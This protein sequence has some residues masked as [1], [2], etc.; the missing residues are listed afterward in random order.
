MRILATILLGCLFS[1]ACLD[2][3]GVST[4]S[5]TDAENNVVS[6]E[7]S[8]STSDSIIANQGNDA[9]RVLGS[10][11]PTLD[12]HMTSD[13]TSAFYVVEIFSGLV[14]IDTNL[15]L[16][17]E[18]AESWKVS[19][20]GKTYTFKL[21]RGVKFHNGKTVRAQD[22]KWSLERAAAP[23][24]ASPVADTYLNDIVGATD[25]MKGNANEIS[26]VTVVDDRTLQ[27]TIDAPKAYFLAKLTYPTAFV[28]DKDVVQAGGRNWWIDNPIGTGPFELKEYRIGERLVLER[29]SKYYKSLA[30][31]DNVIFNLAGG[32]SMAMY[33]NGEI[34]ITGVGLFDIERILDTS[35]P[36]NQ[37]L[38]VAPPGF[39]IY[40]VGFNTNQPPFDDLKFRKA[41]S[42]AIDKELI[43][44]EVLS[45]LSV[46][47]YGILPPG[48]PGYNPNIK[49]LQFDKELAQKLLSESKYAS[50][51][52]RPRIVLTVPGTGGSMGL[53]L[54]VI[55]E[56][57]KSYLGVE[58]E[59]QQV[60]WATYLKDLDEKKFQAFSGLG[61]EADYPDP[62]DFLDI[63]FHSESSLNHGNYKNITADKLLEQA[64][65]ESDV[66]QR[67]S[68]YNEVEEIIVQDA[69]WVPLWFT[70]ERYALVKPYVKGYKFLPM[71]ISKLKEVS[72]ES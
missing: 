30:K 29:S 33:E 18:I 66:K 25:Y 62:Q 65:I 11:P 26:G 45:G 19:P 3:S 48:L 67:F 1:V 2:S 38:E 21:K 56:M 50:P 51:D 37:E 68:I 9:L 34:D 54:E 39:S 72:I 32:Q 20:D 69:P 44:E 58:V 7:K 6:Q 64:R 16:V 63:L 13:T 31:L 59:I 12:P 40:Y 49:G 46:P 42:H 8:K 27:I 10:D 17:P 47:A 24:T 14:S 52:T 60:E 41:L 28:L 71:I 36:L 55:I 22:F 5:Q 70:G 15:Q 61:W 35:N 53:D 4:N 57:W 43:A 23:T